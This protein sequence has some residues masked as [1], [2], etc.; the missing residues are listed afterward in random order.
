MAKKR[1][2]K[3]KIKKS[4]VNIPVSRIILFCAVLGLLCLCLLFATSI[5]ESRPKNLPKNE[6]SVSIT[7]RF[8]EDG[9]KTV[10]ADGLEPE[11]KDKKENTVTKKAEP[12]VPDSKKD[13]GKAASQKQSEVAKKTNSGTDAQKLLQKEPEKKSSQRENENK[14]VEV[15]G[16]VK[17]NTPTPGAAKDLESKKSSETA[18][19]VQNAVKSTYGFPKANGNAK[20]VFLLDDGGQNINQLRNF[21]SLPIPFSVAVLP[22]LVHSKDS[23]ALVRQTG[24]EL[25]LHQPMQAINQN[26]NPGPGAIKPEM[27]ESEIRMTIEKN[28]AEIGPVKGMNNHEGSLITADASTVGII[29]DKAF[30]KNI[31]FLDSRTNVETK[32][33]EVSR[34]KGYAWY[35]RNGNFL[36]NQKTRDEFMKQL[37]KNLEVANRQGHAIM[38]A[39]VWSGDYMPALIR[40]VLPE[41]KSQ[42]YEITTVG[43]LSPRQ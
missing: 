5:L 27:T 17:T 26:V 23:A 7:K 14:P 24:N 28:L 16:P 10:A 39:H 29:L 41:L 15:K 2:S 20:L 36:D 13:S 31:F 18:V 6:N 19:P 3:L 42:G 25:L 35:E 33:P 32:I 4:K 9:K 11:K 43:R 22:G 1:K 38:I 37:K 34:Q 40:E 21:L 12:K 8:E 30:E